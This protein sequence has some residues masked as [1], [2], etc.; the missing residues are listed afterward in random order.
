MNNE[1]LDLVVVIDL[2]RTI[3]DTTRFVEILYI[4]AMEL[5]DHHAKDLRDLQKREQRARGQSFDIVGELTAIKMMPSR[6]T[7]ISYADQLLYPGV[8]ELFKY[9][10]AQG[11]ACIVLTYGGKEAQLMKLR[12]LEHALGRTVSFHITQEKD[13]AAWLKKIITEF[14]MTERART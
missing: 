11:T 12:I 10:E 8:Q 5:P 4:E 14:L 3:F 13:K 2:D 9:L 7:L 6:E 1:A